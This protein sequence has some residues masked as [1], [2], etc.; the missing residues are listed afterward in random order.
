MLT[1]DEVEWLRKVRSAMGHSPQDATAHVEALLRLSEHSATISEITRE[2]V[3]WTEIRRRVA[4]AAR[5]IASLGGIGALL[6]A[7]WDWWPWS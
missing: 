5:F 2:H 1:E 4:N 7:L 3:L 6:A